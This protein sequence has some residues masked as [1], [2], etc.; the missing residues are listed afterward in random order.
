MKWNFSARFDVASG[1][2]FQP[3]H[4]E[5]KNLSTLFYFLT[6]LTLALDVKLVRLSINVF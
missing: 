6:E 1:N 3:R 2:C 5:M 4:P